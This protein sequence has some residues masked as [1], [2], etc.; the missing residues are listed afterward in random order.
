MK[1]GATTDLRLLF[2]SPLHL[3]GEKV[4]DFKIVMQMADFKT[5]CETCKRLCSLEKVLWFNFAS[6]C[7][8]TDCSN[9]VSEFSSLHYNSPEQSLLIMLLY[10]SWSVL[11]KSKLPI[12][13]LCTFKTLPYVDIGYLN[14]KDSDNI[15]H[16][17]L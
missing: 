13:C 12:N 10:C 17:N 4:R 11:L 1:K 2:R 14:F 6:G 16:K 15:E 5:L 8:G 7:W 9:T 3:W